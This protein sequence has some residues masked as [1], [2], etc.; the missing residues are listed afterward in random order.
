MRVV[1]FG[2]AALL[3][4]CV[5]YQV[6]PTA[7]ANAPPV[8][9]APAPAPEAPPPEDSA[10]APAVSVYVEPP[11][12][13][14]APIAVGWAP[15]PMLVEAPPP[16]PFMGAVW[17]GGYWVWQGD[18]VW[19]HGHWVGPPRPDYVW[20]HPYYEHRGEAVIFI[21]GHWAARG[22]AFVP[23]PPTLALVIERPAPG[24]VPGPRP[25][26]PE[27][28]FVPAPP[29]SRR[30]I[31]IPAPVGTAP[32][33]VTSAPAVVAVG[34]RI[35]S[36]PSTVNNANKVTNV[37]NITRVT[38]VTN[39]TIIAPPGATATGHAF[40][41]TVPSAPHLAA[42]RP[43][44]VQAHAPEPVST[45]PLPVY[46]PGSHPPALPHPAP[47]MHP[48][49][50]N[51]AVPA[52]AQG[53]HSV[54]TALEHDPARANPDSARS[55]HPYP[56]GYEHQGQGSAQ[57]APSK[58]PPPALPAQADHRQP[59]PSQADH[60]QPA[61][62][63]ADHKAPPQPQNAYHAAAP[64]QNEHGK[65]SAQAQPPHQGPAARAQG[66]EPSQHKPPAA[67]EHDAKHG[68]GNE[69]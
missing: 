14:P 39:V 43:A 59:A 34:M 42:A 65:G 11:L 4:G 36:T 7:P 62:S 54:P 45:H 57:P 27:G 10:P 69:H 18:W 66:Q 19:A 47:P 9:E 24:V 68:E 60:R 41:S 16:A 50:V 20:V 37:T 58:Q 63:Q 33:V 51:A 55:E 67:S 56:G 49:P 17:V 28:C 26:G 22:A 52:T 40:N 15:P 30:G 12:V 23:P 5:V 3:S 38:N 2:V 8:A 64:A 61:P 53:A 44:L 1:L 48:M 35:S 21:D 6:P 32:A 29:G 13:Q 25:L 31:I 46:T